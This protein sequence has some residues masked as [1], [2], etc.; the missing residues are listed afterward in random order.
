[1]Y[2]AML[3]ILAVSQGAGYG[4]SKDVNR[5]V[6]DYLAPLFHLLQTPFGIALVLV[7]LAATVYAWAH[8]KGHLIFLSAAMLAGMIGFFKSKW[9]AV[10]L[11]GPLV[12]F[13]G[14]SK[15][16]FVFC[17][18]V[19]ALRYLSSGDTAKK[20]PMRPAA[21]VFLVL[22]VLYSLRVVHIAPERALATV[23][24]VGALWVEARTSG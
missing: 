23:L 2:S 5:N 12:A 9:Y 19:L 24:M 15:P 3:E 7:F 16:L 18:A 17:V 6:F 8:P 20:G 1:M 22:Q 21:L 4:V 10:A 13:R 14:V 11:I